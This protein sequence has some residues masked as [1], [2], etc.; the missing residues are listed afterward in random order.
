MSLGRPRIVHVL[1]SIRDGGLEGVV[2][3]LC[4][5]MRGVETEICTLLDEN[6]GAPEL[7]SRGISVREFQGRNRGGLR[8]LGPNLL[9]IV[10]LALHFRRTKP[11]LVVVHD[12]FPGVIGRV[13][14]K[15]GGVR[16]VVATLHS[17]YEWLGTNSRRANRLLG[18]GTSA[19]VCVSEAARQ[20]SQALDGIAPGK[21]WVIRNG[22]DTD[23]FRPSPQGRHQAREDKGWHPDD[24]VIGCVG[25]LRGSKRQIDLVDAVIRLVAK[26]KRPRLILIGTP[27]PHEEAY[28]AALMERLQALPSGLWELWQGLNGLAGVYPMFDA[29]CLPSESEG[30]GLALGEA[31]ASGVACI[32]ADISA[33]REV[34][35]QAA[36]FHAPRDVEGLVDHIELLMESPKVRTELSERGRLRII[37]ELSIQEMIRGWDAL[38]LDLLHRQV[39]TP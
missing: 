4:A 35:G 13:A 31:M 8:M 28:R 33:H 27:R 26:G 37:E 24:F 38:V 16:A 20:A 2:G 30:F 7:R 34:A 14:A 19:V 39:S 22:I 29:V 12:F 21:Y 17:T 18:R 23:V 9:T 25:V 6:P 11:D 10:R 15:L 36:L 5:R 1:T 3:E 32:A